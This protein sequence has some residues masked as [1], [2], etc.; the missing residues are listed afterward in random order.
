MGINKLKHF[1]QIILAIFL[2]FFV[3]LQ[4]A[5]SAVK[6]VEA[7]IKSKTTLNVAKDMVAGKVTKAMEPQKDFVRL[8]K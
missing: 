3:S 5:I 1:S 8:H 2:I 7:I 6:D 4:A